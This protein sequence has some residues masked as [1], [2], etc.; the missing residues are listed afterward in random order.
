MGFTAVAGVPEIDV[1]AGY[2]TVVYEPQYVLGADRT[3]YESVTG[4][5]ESKLPHP[6]PVSLMFWTGA[7]NDSAVIKMA[8]AYEAATH[9]RKPPA[10]FGPIAG[11]P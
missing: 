10:S 11:E 1:P 2:T 6:M 7:G 8:S 4:T 5:V 3:S 9:H